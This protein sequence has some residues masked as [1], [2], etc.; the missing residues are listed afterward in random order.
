MVGNPIAEEKGEEFKKE[1]LIL[2]Y[3]QLPNLKKINGEAFT[4]E[5]ITDAMTLKEERIKDAKAAA[6]EAAAAAA[7]KPEGEEEAPAED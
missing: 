2:L 7:N 1:L 5:D 4:Q 6:E 3:D